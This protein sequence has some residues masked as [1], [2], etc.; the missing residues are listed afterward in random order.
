MKQLI[1]KG[2][3]NNPYDILGRIEVY[4]KYPKRPTVTEERNAKA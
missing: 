1:A 2:I 4:Q 3:E